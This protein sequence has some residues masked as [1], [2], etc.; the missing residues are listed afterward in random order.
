MSEFSRLTA[1]QS[2]PISHGDRTTIESQLA[3][4]QQQE[5]HRAKAVHQTA[6][7]RGQ[8]LLDAD[9]WENSIP[10]TA[11][12]KARSSSASGA[13]DFYSLDL[14]SSLTSSAVRNDMDES[15]VS[16]SSHLSS[17]PPS[18]GKGVE[19]R[20][21]GVGGA[22]VHRRQL[23]GDDMDTLHEGVGL[24][25]LSQSP[26]YSSSPHKHGV[27][28]SLPHKSCPP[29][30]RSTPHPSCMCTL[31]LSGVTLALLEADPS[32]TYTTSNVGG[33]IG[34]EASMDE[35]GLDTVKYFE[36][37]SELLKDGV[38]RHQLALHQEQLAQVL[39][40]DH[41]M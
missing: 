34:G 23:E 38:N 24:Q 10:Q 28:R 29:Q 36:L 25:Q 19:L 16:T 41:L 20:A 30:L 21:R 35:G 8:D 32:H 5:Q 27:P 18:L 11:P 13:D 3:H 12:L 37:V 31:T 1:G 26:P 2:R 14:T 6:R 17:H 40:A 22:T 33:S 15:F 9:P 7:R 4:H 39:P